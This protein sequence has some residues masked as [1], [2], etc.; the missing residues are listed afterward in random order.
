MLEKIEFFYNEDQNQNLQNRVVH[1]SPD[2]LT[3]KFDSFEIP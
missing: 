2:A 1:R 3:V